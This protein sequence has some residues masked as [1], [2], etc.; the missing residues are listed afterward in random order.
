MIHEGDRREVLD[1][2]R[3]E[4][5]LADS[6]VTDPPYGLT[7]VVKR[8]GKDGSAPAKSNGASGVYKRASAGFMGQKWDGT[9]IEQD[10]EFWR[11]CYDVLKPGGHLLAFAGTRTWHRIATAIE[12]AG[13]ELRDTI[14]WLYGTG[15]PKSHDVAKGVAALQ[16]VGSSRTEDIRRLQMGEDYTPSGRGRVNYDH[17]GGSAMNGK[18]A[19]LGEAGA[20]W[21]TALKPAWEPIIVAR[22]PLAGTVAQNVLAHGTG[23][24]SID[25]CRVAH[26]EECRPMAAQKFEGREDRIIRQAIRATATLELK[27]NGRWPANVLHDGSDEVEAAFA[28]FGERPGQVARASRSGKTKSGLVYG[29]MMHLSDLAPPPRGDSG[30]ASRFFYSAKASKDDRNTDWRGEA[31][32]DDNNHPTVKPEGLMR[33]LCRLATP[34]GGL[35]LDPF[36]GSGSTG[37]AARMEGFQ[38]VGIEADPAFCRIARQR[39]GFGSDFA[40]AL[41]RL[42]AATAR[43]TSAM[44]ARN[45]D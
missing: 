31:I 2:L 41:A 37:K 38:F 26:N 45:G 1:R 32:A 43:L 11:L 24:I 35:V 30:S 42:K 19:P 7:S 6:I 36:C 25:G 9:G 14:M 17:G 28:A 27:P 23:A 15:F 44:E 4:G 40:T 16:A 22:K 34:P 13:F 29:R 3:R 10:P 20:G 39:G 33:W 12:D 5:L 8:F 18:S 21:G